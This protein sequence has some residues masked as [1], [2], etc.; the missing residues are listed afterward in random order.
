VADKDG[1]LRDG[2]AAEDLMGL[3]VM[4]LDIIDERIIF[5]VGTVQSALDPALA[6]SPDFLA[7]ITFV[8]PETHQPTVAAASGE[9]KTSDEYAT[10]EASRE[11]HVVMAGRHG[12]PRPRAIAVPPTTH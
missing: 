11:V 8:H 7:R 9:C 2:L 4:E 3:L 5:T 12:I 6:C 1:R 10:W